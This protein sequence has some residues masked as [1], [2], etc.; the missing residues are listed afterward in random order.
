[1]VA[2]LSQRL[3]NFF[4]NFFI[5]PLAFSGTLRLKLFSKN[6]DFSLFKANSTLSRQTA[7]I[8]QIFFVKSD[9]TNFLHFLADFRVMGLFFRIRL[10]LSLTRATSLDLIWSNYN[11]KDMTHLRNYQ[12]DIRYAQNF[13]WHV[14]SLINLRVRFFKKNFLSRKKGTQIIFQNRT[15][16]IDW[17]GP[18]HFSRWREWIT[19][20]VTV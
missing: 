8:L 7:T 11:I 5:S 6:V 20:C 1:M 15:G 18:G 3:V 17:T 13:F 10:L 16:W 12:I 4:W 9:F 2:Q 14:S 19:D